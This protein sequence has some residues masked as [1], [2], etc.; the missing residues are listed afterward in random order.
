VIKAR[1]PSLTTGQ[2]TYNVWVR[3]HRDGSTIS[4][5]GCPC[6]QG[7]FGKCK[8]VYKVLCRIAQAPIPGPTR[9]DYAEKARKQRRAEQL[10]HASVYIAIACKSELD[11]GKVFRRSRRIKDNVDQEILG[12]F[13]SKKKANECARAHLGMDEDDEDGEDDE[14]DNDE[15]EDYCD[16]DDDD[17]DDEEFNDDDDDDVSMVSDDEATFVYDGSDEGDFDEEGMFEKVWVERRAI[18]DASRRFHK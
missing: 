5:S 4:R 9:Q 8:H 11:S 2:G 6:P 10:E 15:E 3:I 12:I 1:I 7:V 14:D 13:F 16:C 17:D 18:D